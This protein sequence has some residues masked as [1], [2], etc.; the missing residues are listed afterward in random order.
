MRKTT[1]FIFA[2]SMLTYVSVFADRL[3]DDLLARGKEFEIDDLS[4]F[5]HEPN[6]DTSGPIGP[7]NA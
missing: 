4:A 6:P 2:I 7:F 5:S 1:Q 3:D